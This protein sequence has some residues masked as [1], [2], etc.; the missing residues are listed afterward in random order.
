LLMPECQN[1][2]VRNS[3]TCWRNRRSFAS[4][5]SWM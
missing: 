1:E 3:N 2:P 4:R 5:A